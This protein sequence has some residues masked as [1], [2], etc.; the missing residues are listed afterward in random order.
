MTAES[1]PYRISL[2]APSGRL[3]DYQWTEESK[4]SHGIWVKV[5]WEGQAY[6]VE[7]RVALSLDTDDVEATGLFLGPRDGK[8]GVAT[9]T[10]RSLRTL[11][12]NDILF[13]LE[14]L[15]DARGWLRKG[16][17][18]RQTVAESLGLPAPTRYRAPR[19]HPGPKGWPR[20]H[21]EAIAKAYNEIRER[22][23]HSPMQELADQQR[24]SLP[25]VR[26]WLVRAEE[27]GF[28]VNRPRSNKTA[29]RPEVADERSPKVSDEKHREERP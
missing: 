29:P 17:S 27:M 3:I 16:T 4:D 23:P 15:Q 14:R 5:E 8:P 13:G 18:G 26:R 25:Q 2:L 21:F 1:R 20:E 11:P 9:V 10:T 19:V 7:V 22:N 6:D 12:L 28:Q 24:K